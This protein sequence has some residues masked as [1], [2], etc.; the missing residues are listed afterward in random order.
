MWSAELRDRA[1]P[2]SLQGG[3]LCLQRLRISLSTFSHTLPVSA[4]LCMPPALESLLGCLE[5]SLVKTPATGHLSHLFSLGIYTGRPFKA[6]LEDCLPFSC[7]AAPDRHM[8]TEKHTEMAG[9]LRFSSG[10]IGAWA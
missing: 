1:P 9:K 5:P 8:H 7:D 4:D 6:S 3:H 10:D 2:A